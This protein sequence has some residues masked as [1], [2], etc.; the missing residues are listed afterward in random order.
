MIKF[1]KRLWCRMTE[2]HFGFNSQM[3]VMCGD[4]FDKTFFNGDGSITSSEYDN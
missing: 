2:H 4:S 1:I 3:C